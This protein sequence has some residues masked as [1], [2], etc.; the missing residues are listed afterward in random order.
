MAE[1]RQGDELAS[2]LGKER[3]CRCGDAYDAL[4]EMGRS[5]YAAVVLTAPRTGFDGLCRASRRLQRDAKLFALCPPAAEPEVRDLT[6]KVLDDYFIDPPTDRDLRCMIRAA[7]GQ[8]VSASAGGVQ[9]ALSGPEL[10]EMVKATRTVAQLESRIAAVVGERC[11]L[12]AIWTDG[13][14]LSHSAEPLLHAADD[15]QRVLIS[16]TP[17]GRLDASGL[18]FLSTVQDCLPALLATARRSESLRRLA[19]TDHLTGAHNRRYFYHVTDQILLRGDAKSFRVTL[20]L[21]DID[22][23]KR[24]NDTYGHAAGDEILREIARLIKRTTRVQDIVA[25]IGGDEFAV[26]FW[27]PA[28][29]RQPNSQPPEAAYIVAER[30]RKAVERHEFPALGSE[31]R[32]SLTISGGLASF[33]DDGRSC[34]ELLRSADRALKVVKETGKNA[35]LLIGR[36]T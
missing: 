30:F 17:T 15:S 31:A 28:E 5:R 4:L 33:P 2:R 35:T 9:P 10:A 22:E 20:L 11:G 8:T 27:D 12:E 16:K 23:F 3:T 24:Y 32:G 7:S 1:G 34:R 6:G 18:E 26:L 25:R 21:F 29:P 19:I 13:K 36:E 14:T